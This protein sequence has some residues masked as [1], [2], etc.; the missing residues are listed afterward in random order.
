MHDLN[1][2]KAKTHRDQ[3]KLLALASTYLLT[4]NRSQGRIQDFLFRKYRVSF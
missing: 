2:Q 3:T 4:Q 1:L